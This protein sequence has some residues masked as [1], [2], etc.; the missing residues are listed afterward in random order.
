MAQSC[1]WDNRLFHEDRNIFDPGY[2]NWVCDLTQLVS[3]PKTPFLPS[4]A[5]TPLPPSNAPGATA[6]AGDGDEKDVRSTGD[7]DDVE[8]TAAKVALYLALDTVARAKDKGMLSQLM[9]YVRS[10]FRSKPS[11]CRWALEEVPR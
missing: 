3:P 8:D 9:L 5:S 11:V 6:E 2:I 1:W 7:V 10:W 4:A